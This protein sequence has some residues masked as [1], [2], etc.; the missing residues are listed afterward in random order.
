M[1]RFNN[2]LFDMDGTL[3]D[4]GPG[5]KRC[6]QYALEGCGI[7]E[8]DQE[9]LDR[10]MG[11]PL[12]YSFHTFYGM[13]QEQIKTAVE[14]FRSLYEKEGI[15]E[16][17]PYPGT[18]A[19]LQRCKQEGMRLAVASSKPQVHVL[20][21]LERFEMKQYFDVIV[22]SDINKEK[23][24]KVFASDKEQIV[25]DALER[26]FL[27]EK[28]EEDSYADK[29]AP[30][31]ET[32]QRERDYFRQHTAMVGDR[33]FDMQGAK[34][35]GVYGIGVQFGYGSDEELLTAGADAL[36]SDNETLTQ[37]LL[38]TTS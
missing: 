21:V 13:D 34:T 35:N 33:R 4:S 14:R 9:K 8:N 15:W 2:V 3:T 36:V 18:I 25:A 37:M 22:G 23:D 26:L 7:T 12:N 19:M 27:L 1:R 16:N 11:P 32:L 17:S 38:Q 24:G 29:T 10:F 31:E 20:Q 5:V 6:V 30:D 28:K